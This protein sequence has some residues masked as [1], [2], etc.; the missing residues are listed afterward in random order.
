MAEEDYE[1]WCIC[2]TESRPVKV[3]IS[4]TK[5]IYDLTDLIAEK[6]FSWNYTAGD[7]ILTKVR[8]IMISMQRYDLIM[9]R[10]LM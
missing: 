8:Y 3:F 2:E 9:S 1:L 5:D 6:R 4:P 10:R 7:L